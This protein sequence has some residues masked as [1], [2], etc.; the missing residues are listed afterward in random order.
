MVIFPS[1]FPARLLNA[2]E[3][4]LVLQSVD[5]LSWFRCDQD[6]FMNIPLIKIIFDVVNTETSYSQKLSSTICLVL[7]SIHLDVLILD[8]NS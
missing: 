4:L 1:T 6:S 5:N 3:S 7:H 2:H 8:C